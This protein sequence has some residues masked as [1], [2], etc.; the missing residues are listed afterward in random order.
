MIQLSFLLQAGGNPLMT[1]IL[2]MT[3]MFAIAYFFLFR[4]Q[5]KQKKEQQKFMDE[6]KRG[7]EVVTSGGIIGKVNKIDEKEVTLQTSEK[8]FIR[9][10]RSSLSNEMTMA[11]NGVEK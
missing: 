4:P 5:A 7:D 3:A 11:R 1:N 6:L 8:T 9:I 10:Q 2:F